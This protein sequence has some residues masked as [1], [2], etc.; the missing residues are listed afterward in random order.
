MGS[1]CLYILIQSFNDTPQ[2]AYYMPNIISHYT[3]MYQYQFFLQFVTF[4]RIRVFMPVYMCVCV[5]VSVCVFQVFCCIQKER[6]IKVFYKDNFPRKKSH[7]LLK[8]FWTA[9]TK[10]VSLVNK[11]FW[12][13][14]IQGP[15][16]IFLSHRMQWLLLKCIVTLNN[17]QSLNAL[18]IIWIT[19]QSS[20]YRKSNDLHQ[21]ECI[22]VK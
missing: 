11:G 17:W 16:P 15:P 22:D 5:C 21:I 3:N 6:I 4:N 13:F 18:L 19:L 2:S 1:L 20:I 8:K 9:N 12:K 7:D 14:D 10:K